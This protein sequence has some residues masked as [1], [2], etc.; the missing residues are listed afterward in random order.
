MGKISSVVDGLAGK[1]MAAKQT[2]P[3]SAFADQE[4]HQSFDGD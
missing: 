1:P 4:W 2:Q 3:Q